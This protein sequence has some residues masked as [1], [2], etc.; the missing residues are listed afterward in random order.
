MLIITFYYNRPVEFWFSDLRQEN[1]F[2]LSEKYKKLY[3]M[4]DNLSEKYLN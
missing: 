1:N 3:I 4:L 2:V